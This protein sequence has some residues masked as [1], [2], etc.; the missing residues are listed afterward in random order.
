MAFLERAEITATAD[1]EEIL[2][3]RYTDNYVTVYPGEFVEIRSKTLNP[4]AEANWV[5]VSR[6]NTAPV[7]VPVR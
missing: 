3:V 1:G 2:P 6:Y 4:S 7:E 5:R